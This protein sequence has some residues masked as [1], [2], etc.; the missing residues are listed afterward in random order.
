MRALLAPIFFI[1]FTAIGWQLALMRCLLVSR[2]HHFSF[3][4]ISCALLGFGAGGVVLSL[5]ASW[6]TQH[7][8]QIIRW[9]VLCFGLCVPLCFRLGELLPLNVYF[10]PHTVVSAIGWW[11]VFWLIHGIPFLL[12]GILI[13]GAL[14]VAG[15]DA[16]RVYAW[17]LVGSAAGALGMVFLMDHLPANVL[18]V[19]VAAA[20]LLSGLWLGE[21]FRTP[22]DR[23]YAASLALGLLGMGLIWV[24]GAERLFPLHIDQYKPLA[25]VHRLE[26]QGSAT[27]LATFHSARGRLDLY[28]SPTFHTML[29][30]SPSEMPPRMHMLLRDGFEIGSI[31]SIEKIERA[32]FLHGTLAALPYKLIQP[33]RVLILGETGGHHIWLARMSQ[34]ESIVVVQPD[35]NIIEALRRYGSSVLDDPRIHVITSEPRAYLDTAPETFDVVHLAALEGFLAGTAG[36][37]G[38]REDY[39]A[40]VEGFRKCLDVLTDRGL[41]SI[42]RGIQ[43]PE[44]DNI[45]I[46]A[47]WIESLE[48]RSVNRPG[49]HLLVA[50]DELAVSTLASK[51]P[52]R[53]EV[54]EEFRAAA[55]N[56]SWET[57]W[58][59]GIE[60]EETNRIHVL[61]GPPS[62]A[63]SWYYH[64]M[65]ALLSSGREDFFR[66]WIAHI[67]P[68]T[69]D[70][71][72]FSD[73]FRTSSIGRLREAFGPMWATRSEMGFLVLVWSTGMTLAFAVVLLLAPLLLFGRGRAKGTGPIRFCVVTYFGL[74]GT[75][76]MCVEMSLIQLFTRFLG[77]P[78]LAAALVVAG[79][80]F[81]AGLGS[82]V[83]PRVTRA[84]PLGAFGVAVAVALAIVLYAKGLPRLFESGAMLAGTWKNAVGL[85][86]LA[87]LAAL[88]G[89]LFPWGLST[90]QR[91]A[92]PAIPLAWAVNGFASVVSASVAVV[93]AMTLG[94]S[95]LLGCAAAA[96]GLAGVGSLLLAQVSW[97]SR[98]SS[99][100]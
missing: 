40:T 99:Q 43:E 23:L 71:P 12:A 93:L 50:R 58:F 85:V 98:L 90:L 20:V 62:S 76:F 48:Q 75:G 25:Q 66:N 68:A 59:P 10:A 88:M 84:M 14:M 22:Q 74:L 24:F 8:R 80:L 13:G 54:I 39:L 67:R 42:V 51:A 11:G 26:C 4:V 92:A 91:E 77:D 32:R 27:R 9:G 33:G 35:R 56:M 28:T 63:V 19:P 41:V 57:E 16:H 37:G 17:N 81:C 49:D 60:P 31:L 36:I 72:F 7:S 97:E 70:R 53:S 79:L 61:P 15:P 47:T 89:M 1:S 65:V 83:Q 2:Y 5:G 21:G 29:S 52:L 96:Y 38:L 34:A 30:L 46:A 95:A 18:M 100:I 69:D 6:F 78:V 86:V 45:K 73:F 82:M 44:R 87:P 94:F 3:L 55:R 64:A